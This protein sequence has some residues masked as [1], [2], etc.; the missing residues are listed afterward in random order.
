MWDNQRFDSMAETLS[1]GEDK[2][3]ESITK[4][5]K[6]EGFSSEQIR[7]LGRLTNVKLFNKKHAEMAN[8][9][10]RIVDFKL[11]DPEQIINSL[12]LEE[13]QAKTAS[14]AASYP[15]LTNEY[16]VPPAFIPMDK[17]ANEVASIERS[18]GPTINPE[19]KI[20]N[21]ERLLKDTSIEINIADLHW[22]TAMENVR[23]HCKNIYFDFNEFEK[24]ALACFGAEIVPELNAIRK[25]L[26]KEM[27]TASNEKLAELSNNL[28]FD[29]TKET[30][31]L[32]IALD[33]RKAYVKLSTDKIKIT[34][35][36]KNTYNLIRGVK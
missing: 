4:L 25:E 11:V 33:N 22:K 1:K 15:D 8:Q 16:E 34:E 20:A 24:N 14:I 19:T 29:E 23:D 28:I 27:I 31:I 32:K 9:D 36:L 7:R 17:I 13:K 5:A 6:E 35:D 12:K 21:L 3:V 18:L 10:N 26:K 2:I 30:K